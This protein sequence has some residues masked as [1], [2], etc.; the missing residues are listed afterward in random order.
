MRH[1]TFILFSIFLLTGCLSRG[2]LQDVAVSNARSPQE[3]RD[4]L[5]SYATGEHSASWER[6]RYL[7]YGEEDDNFISNLV[8]T[9]SASE[10][11]DCVKTFYSKKAEEAENNFRKKCFSDDNCKKNILVNENSKELNQQYNLLI[12]YNRFQSGDADY[13]ARLV[14][15]TIANNQRA[16][17]PR[18]QSEGIIR[19]ISGI[20]PISRDILVKIGD[21][22]WM[23]SSYGYHDPMRLL[24]SPR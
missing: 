11:R 17:M 3:K 5:L 20:D 6:S 16:G 4:V 19:G 8:I 14:C 2:Q 18:N 21:A 9:C 7:N 22:C 15:S 10:D 24:S 13:M 1:S 12:S 23:L